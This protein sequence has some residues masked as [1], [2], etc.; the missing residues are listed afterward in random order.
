MTFKAKR[1]ATFF[2]LITFAIIVLAAS[3]LIPIIYTIFYESTTEWIAVAILLVSFI[4]ASGF[5][6]WISLDIEYV[7]HEEYLLVRGGPFRSK[8][9]YKDITRFFE[10]NNILVGYRILSS[11]DALEIQYKTGIFGSVIISPENKHQ[12]IEEL[13]KRMSSKT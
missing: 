7:F 2:T 10:S 13:Q 4:V 6:I 8:I 11:K 12:F 1:D 5:I 3:T 9:P